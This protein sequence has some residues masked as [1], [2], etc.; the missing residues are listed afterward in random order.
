MIEYKILNDRVCC[1]LLLEKDTA[2]LKS[3]K[4]VTELEN[5]MIKP[6]YL[7]AMS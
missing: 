3:M 7:A 6:C 4:R 2:F 1:I 5:S